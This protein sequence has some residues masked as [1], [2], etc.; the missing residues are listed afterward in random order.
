MLVG[1]PRYLRTIRMALMKEDEVGC[2]IVFLFH[3]L[4][5]PKIPK[6]QIGICAS[7]FFFM[8]T[9]KSYVKDLELPLAQDCPWGARMAN[10]VIP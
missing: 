8:L 9:K 2:V 1:F 7:L 4:S 3:D 10:I 6:S 5:F